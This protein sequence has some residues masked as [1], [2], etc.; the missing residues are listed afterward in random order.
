M[1]MCKWALSV[2]SPEQGFS[3]CQPWLG[4]TSLIFGP[5]SID[6]VNSLH[7]VVMADKSVA[8]GKENRRWKA[9]IHF[10][11]LTYKVVCRKHF[12]WSGLKVPVK[13]CLI[14]F[15]YMIR[16]FC[17]TLPALCGLSASSFQLIP[18]GE[19]VYFEGKCLACIK[20]LQYI[21]HI[22]KAS[23]ERVPSQALNKASNRLH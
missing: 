20:G 7:W 18:L 2:S 5:H 12:W 17:L 4:T 15:P 11:L 21:K 19:E 10:L 1:T 23:V 3:H 22:S 8:Q 6:A 16:S 9:Q 14:S 13:W